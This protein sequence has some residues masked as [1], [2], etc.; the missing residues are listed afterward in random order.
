MNPFIETQE[1]LELRFIRFVIAILV[2]IGIFMP[3]N[4]VVEEFWK[5]DFSIVGLFIVL[6]LIILTILSLAIS[7]YYMFKSK[8]YRWWYS[9]ILITCMFIG[10][11]WALLLNPDPFIVYYG[12]YTWFFLWIIIAASSNQKRAIVLTVSLSSAA[13]VGFLMFKNYP[14]PTTLLRAPSKTA[15]IFVILTFIII[16][17]VL[18]VS[19]DNS[20]AME[21]I[22]TDLSR[23]HEGIALTPGT[24]VRNQITV[25]V[26]QII[27]EGI[28]TGDF[29]LMRHAGPKT[30]IILGDITGNGINASP[31]VGYVSA[32]FYSYRGSWSPDL[33]MN[34]LNNMS[35]RFPNDIS[36]TAC[37]LVINDTIEED[38]VS[39]EYAGYQQKIR[40][41]PRNP[42]KLPKQYDTDGPILG[43]T[44]NIPFSKHDFNINP[45]DSFII[46]TDG[47]TEH[48]DLSILTVTK[49]EK[50]N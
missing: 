37:C 13:V 9:A 36:Y 3:I 45:G 40:L 12:G 30:M 47:K 22:K 48:E 18:F 41:I 39:V 19:R 35:V 1:K 8:G 29:I 4:L 17:Y 5:K 46:M 16:G 14:P 42:K 34:Y 11:S 21:Q 43:L 31:Y 27:N 10:N 44:K 28:T 50:K 6:E 32:L 38:S 24:Y 49:N 33:V 20:L 23:A 26:W 7:F 25:E 15:L 2:F